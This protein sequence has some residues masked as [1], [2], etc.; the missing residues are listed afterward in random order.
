MNSDKPRHYFHPAARLL[1][2]RLGTQGRRNAFSRRFRRA[3]LFKEFLLSDSGVSSF[4][5]SPSIAGRRTK[6]GLVI[7][8]SVF[9]PAVLFILL[10]V[11]L[12]SVFPNSMARLFSSAQ[13]FIAAKL[14][15]FYILAVAIILCAMT[16]IAVSRFGSIRL[17][18]DHARPAFS[19]PVWFAMLFSTGMGIGIMFFGIAEPVM[20]FLAPPE[21]EAQTVAAARSA[22]ETTFF[23]WGLH[24]WA[25]YAA[26]GLML[27]YFGFRRGLP[28]TLRSA[29]YPLIGE[30]IYGPIGDAADVFAVTG[31]VFGVATSL[32]FGVLQINSGLGYLFGVSTSTSLQMALIFGISALSALSA[33]SGLNRGIK[34]LS[35][36]NLIL[37]VLLLALV[38]AVGPTAELLKH[39]VENTGIYL[40]GLITKTFTLYA[41]EPQNTEWLGGWTLQ[42]W[43]W[44]I[45]WSPFV[46]LFIAQISRGRT[47]REFLAG[48]LLI[49][50]GFTLLWMTAFGNSAIDLI[51][52]GTGSA[53]AAA[54]S[55]DVSTA[56]YKFFEYLPGTPYLCA[57]GMGMVIVF[58][59]TSADSGAFVSDTIASGGARRTPPAQRVFWAMLPA[60]CAAVLLKAGGL[61]ALQTMTLVS[62]LPF[63]AV[64]LTSLCGLLRS[65]RYDD[66]RRQTRRSTVTSSAASGLRDDWRERLRTIVTY[67]TERD[68]RKWFDR[69]IVP[70]LEDIST[71]F[72]KAS[73]AARVVRRDDAVALT[74]VY[75]EVPDFLYEVRLRHYESPETTPE[76]DQSAFSRAEV[77]LREGS[78]DYDLMGWSREQIIHDVLDQY[79]KHL[80]FLRAVNAPSVA[81]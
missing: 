33:A 42:Y 28:L 31:T 75:P 24:A 29:L 76:S 56:L 43:G 17:G 10:C 79:E 37:A 46:G 78:R 80:T 35:E 74:V 5:P 23:H 12:A 54:V 21:G 81:T 71:E 52:S 3:S 61:Q 67:P 45:S 8:R 32:G 6:S 59:V 20:H 55:N 16:L 77:F 65:L 72:E 47:I 40:S 1:T 62:A 19:L 38:F 18:P 44:W 7:R 41:Y 68:V 2:Y 51:M 9:W 13:D 63:A 26:V 69:T 58:F 49:P 30:R 27:A 34:L 64:L 53:L 66:M 39:F 22:L 70:A 15:W 50:A 73:L 36:A 57:I 11:G 25:I 14:S 4:C 60:V 48:V